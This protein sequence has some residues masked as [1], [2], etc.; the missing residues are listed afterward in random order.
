MAGNRI[1]EAMGC[2]RKQ[3]TQAF[4]PVCTNNHK[5]CVY[6]PGGSANPLMRQIPL[7]GGVIVLVRKKFWQ[8][9]LG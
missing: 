6:F 4:A 2:R 5:V 7:E 9:A 1:T 8:A 3:T